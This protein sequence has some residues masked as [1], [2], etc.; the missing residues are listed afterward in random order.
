MGD[1]KKAKKKQK[2][3]G[4]KPAKRGRLAKVKGTAAPPKSKKGK[5]GK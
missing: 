1:K 3:A 2:K 5:K 4:P